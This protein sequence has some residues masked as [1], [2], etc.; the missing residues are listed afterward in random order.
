MTD[1]SSYAINNTVTF[2][3][4][5]HGLT[6]I[7]IQSDLAEAEI[8]LQG[9]NITH[10]QPHGQ[11]PLLFDAKSIEMDPTKT[12][13]AGIPLCWPWFG[14]HPSDTTKPQHGFARTSLWEIQKTQLHDDGKVEIVL[15]LTQNASTR[16]LFDFDFRLEITFSIAKTLSVSLTTTNTDTKAFSFTDAIH[17]YFAIGDIAQMKIKGVQETPFIDYTDEQKQKSE[18]LPLSIDKE[19]NR[20]YIPTL[21]SCTIVDE[22]LKREIIVSKKG[23]NSTTIW[24]P[25]KENGI[26][27]LVNDKYRYF[28][29]IESVN[30]LE[31]RIHLE[32]SQSHTITQL[33]SIA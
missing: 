33:I 8:Y 20:V 29:C 19:V 32:P 23:S 26:H 9:A 1:L 12:L 18:T 5:P 31:D 27:D 17:T 6:K 28:V 22:V 16:K 15:A 25:W 11:K 21:E 24:N 7:I 10:F 30:A 2:T 3:T 4:N 14:P 13:H